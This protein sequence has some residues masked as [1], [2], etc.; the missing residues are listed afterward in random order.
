ML[1]GILNEFENVKRTFKST[2]A[3]SQGNRSLADEWNSLAD[4]VNAKAIVFEPENKADNLFEKPGKILTRGI[5]QG[6]D[7]AGRCIIKTDDKTL[8]FTQ[9]S[10]SLAFLNP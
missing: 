8:Y 7:P 2:A 4:C 3:Y 1:I 9:G 5:F 10:V 6:I